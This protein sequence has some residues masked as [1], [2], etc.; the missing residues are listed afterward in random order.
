MRKFVHPSKDDL[1]LAAVLNALADPMRLAILKKLI[2]KKEGASCCEVAPCAD[3]AKSTLSHHFRVL[4]EA[5]LVRT[6]KVG[7]EHSNA[8]R[9]K[10][11]NERF[12]GLLTLILKLTE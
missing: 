8:I 4:R 7:V 12:P 11:I 6:T 9:L 3:M 1:T 5:G 10:D 2:A